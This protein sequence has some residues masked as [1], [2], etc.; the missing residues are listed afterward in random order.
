MAVALRVP[1]YDLAWRIHTNDQALTAN[2]TN[3]RNDDGNY[4]VGQ[5]GRAT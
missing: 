3:R 4:A 5:G 1:S 2:K